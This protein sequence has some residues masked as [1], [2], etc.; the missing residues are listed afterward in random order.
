MRSS[1]RSTSSSVTSWPSRV[2][3]ST[4]AHRAVDD[5]HA[6]RHDLLER[7]GELRVLRGAP[8]GAA[9]HS[10]CRPAPP[11]RGRSAA[12]KSQLRRPCASM[13]QIDDRPREQTRLTP[14]CCD[15][16]ESRDS[17]ASSVCA[18]RVGSPPMPGGGESETLPKDTPSRGNKHERGG[19]RPPPGRGRCAASHPAPAGRGRQSTGA[20]SDDEGG[21]Q[22][23][24]AAEAEPGVAGDGQPAGRRLD[25]AG[26]CVRRVLAIVGGGPA[27]RI[28]GPLDG[29]PVSAGRLACNGLWPAL[30]MN[31]VTGAVEKDHAEPH[32]FHADHWLSLPEAI[33]QATGGLNRRAPCET[34]APMTDLPINPAGN[35]DLQALQRGASR[36][37][38]LGVVIWVL[39]L[40]FTQSRWRTAPASARPDRGRRALAD[41]GVHPGAHVVHALHRR[42]QEAR[43]RHRG[44][45]FGRA[46]PPLRLQRSIGAAGIGAQNGRASCSRSCFCGDA[47]RVPG[48]GAAGGSISGR[49]V[50]GEFAAYSARVPASG[51]A[52]RCGR[53]PTSCG[54]GRAWCAAR[55]SM[56]ACSCW[57]CPQPTWC[58]WLQQARRLPVLFTLP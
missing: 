3:S 23:Q 46:Q 11:A 22:Q 20:T 6:D 4:I 55:F 30:P 18:L 25:G 50:S 8:H 17:C 10:G 56:R 44:P 9:R 48:G 45:L 36:C 34:R 49:D 1:A 5:G 13:L 16:R 28:A 26:R 14:R 37:W 43:A 53:R 39:L 29:S 40:L 21:D 58:A 51:R 19:A 35:M 52:S 54:S 12:A 32:F 33:R 7:C 2:R 27:C 41:P 31:Y 42:P 38:P 15:R 57:R 47:G 24:H